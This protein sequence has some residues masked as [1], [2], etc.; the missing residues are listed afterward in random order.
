M[1]K[2][3][4]SLENEIRLIKTPKFIVVDGPA[5]EGLRDAVLQA[6]VPFPHSYK[7]FVLR[8]GNAKLYRELDYYKVGVFAAPRKEL[9]A[10]TGQ[11]F[12][13]FGHYD[14]CGAYFNGS[15]LRHNEETPVFEGRRDEFEQ[16]A[17]SFD[18]WLDK[19]RASARKTYSEEAWSRIVAGP[20]PFSQKEMGIVH[21]RRLFECR[22][23][24]VAADGKKLVVQVHNG[25]SMTLPFLSL[26]LR[27]KSTGLRGGVWL[28]VSHVSPGQSARIEH[29]TYVERPDPADIELFL[30]P[31]PGPEDRE[32]YWEFNV[33][34][35]PTT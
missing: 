15:L 25:S 7:E 2:M 1:T 17:D 3:F 21:A 10:D 31:D 32:Q 28:P 18:E 5:D 23:A 11:A 30:R 22:L 26:G 4:E 14:S 6:Q 9:N 20:R 35:V 16:V 8:F 12:Y 19:R 24:G 33:A 29:A 13:R 27:W 34:D